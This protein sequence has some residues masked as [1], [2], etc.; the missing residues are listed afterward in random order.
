MGTEVKKSAFEYV[1]HDGEKILERDAVM[2]VSREQ[3]LVLIGSRTKPDIDAAGVEVLLR[4]FCRE[5]K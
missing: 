2:A 5:F 3:A 1:I 4:P